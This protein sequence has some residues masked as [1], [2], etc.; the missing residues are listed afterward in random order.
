MIGDVQAAVDQS[1][2]ESGQDLILQP[3]AVAA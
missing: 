1:T 2:P 3:T